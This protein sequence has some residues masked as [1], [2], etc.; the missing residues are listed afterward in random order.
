LNSGHKILK[1]VAKYHTASLNGH[2]LKG[3]LNFLDEKNLGGWGWFKIFH[4][5]E[6]NFD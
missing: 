2:I 5:T 1:I 4:I 6:E 3:D